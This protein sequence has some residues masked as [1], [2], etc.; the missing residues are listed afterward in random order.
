MFSKFSEQV[1][2]ATDRCSV[3]KNAILQT[4]V[5]TPNGNIYSIKSSN[6]RN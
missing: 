5:T 3:K 1:I 4:L 2:K 6:P